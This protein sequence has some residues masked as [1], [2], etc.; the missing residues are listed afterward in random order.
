MSRLAAA[1]R[2]PG[3]GGDVGA[4]HLQVAL[5]IKKTI[6]LEIL[7]A[8]GSVKVVTSPSPIDGYCQ[9]TDIPQSQGKL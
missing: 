9:A 5:L 8:M 1:L 3:D 4:S 2:L 6:L 7:T